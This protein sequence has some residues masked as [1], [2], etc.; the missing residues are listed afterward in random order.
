M[1]NESY[2]KL[3]ASGLPVRFAC[4]SGG[5]LR[6]YVGDHFE[7]FYDNRRGRDYAEAMAPRA[8]NNSHLDIALHNL[9]LRIPEAR[10]DWALKLEKAEQARA[11]RLAKLLKRKTNKNWAAIEA[12]GNEFFSMLFE[13]IASD[14]ENEE[15]KRAR[16]GSWRDRCMA[17][18]VK[19]PPI[20]AA[21]EAKEFAAMIPQAAPKAAAARI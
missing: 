13:D 7:E 4:G 1:K 5:L 10:A 9:A 20:A 12:A 6:V 14:G 21:I 8:V 11:E 16:A 15:Y 19:F 17:E 2:E 18:W 3:I